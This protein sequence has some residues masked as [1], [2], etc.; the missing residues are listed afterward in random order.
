M[1]QLVCNGVA[2][3]L[4]A[5]TR[6]QFK[7]NNPA[8]AFG[9]MSAERTTQIKIPATPTND[10]VF[11]LARIPAYE[12]AKMRVKLPAILQDGVVVNKGM[13]YVTNYDG[14]EYTAVFVGGLAF[15]IK[16]FGAHEY[17]SLMNIGVKLES[18]IYDANE[19][20][21][22]MVARVKYRGMPTK[23]YLVPPSVDLEQL[24]EALNAQGVFPISGLVGKHIRV[25][26]SGKIDKRDYLEYELKESRE[27]AEILRNDPTQADVQNLGLSVGN[28]ILQVGTMRVWIRSYSSEP[29]DYEERRIKC[30]TS[31]SFF[32]GGYYVTFPE[33]MPENLCACYPKW[34]GSGQT[35][36]YEEEAEVGFFGSRYFDSNGEYHGNPLAGKTVYISGDFVLMTAEGAQADIANILHFDGDM[37][38]VPAYNLNV[39]VSG[40]LET[41]YTWLQSLPFVELLKIYS[42]CTGRIIN[43][44]KDGSVEFIGDIDGE[45]ILI[46]KVTKTAEVTRTVAD[47]AQ[48]NIIKFDDPDW[49]K[50]SERL[51]VEYQI[52]N[53]N[54]TER[55][56][57]LTIEETAGGLYLGDEDA[58]EFEFRGD[59]GDEQRMVA[60]SDAGTEYMQRVSLERSGVIEDLCEKST[61]INVSCLMTIAEFNEIDGGA[62]FILNNTLYVWTEARWSDGVATIQLAKI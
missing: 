37:E 49:V 28:G 10:R 21:I 32:V 31:G 15:D 33:N 11:E 43:V 56:D 45:P 61:S 40:I 26:C 35:G 48:V 34:S 41:I 58:N 7:K 19:S 50:E 20:E 60:V 2:L 36:V 30:F 62:S 44:N 55:K 24:F 25:I 8:F 3:D 6:V 4:N 52:E 51:S 47:W 13:L 18:R 29:G 16:N 46:D 14:D 23:S 27:V 39:R 38:D 57:L 54:I 59:G 9:D 1:M 22:P 53:L 17:G 5:G 12:G 42:A